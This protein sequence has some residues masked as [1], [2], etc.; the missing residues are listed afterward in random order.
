MAWNAGDYTKVS[1]LQDKM[2]RMFAARAI[3]VRVVITNKFKNIAGIYGI[4]WHTPDKCM[5]AIHSLKDLSSYKASTLKQLPM[6]I[7]KQENNMLSHIP[8]MNDRAVQVLFYLAL[9]P[10]AESSADARNYAFRPF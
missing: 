6:H 5:A 4:L 8:T 3:A 1:E 2:V 9:I 7:I 10:I